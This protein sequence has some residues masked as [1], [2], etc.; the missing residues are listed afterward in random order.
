MIKLAPSI[1]AADF[2]R[3]GEVI[4]ET[5]ESEADLIH[6]DVMDGQ[7]VPNITLGADIVKAIRPYT[8]K[9]FD[10]HLMVD[11]PDR[12]I[13]QF[14]DAGADI[15]TVHV[16]TCAHLHRTIQMIKSRGIKAG[17]VL[18]PAT[19][20]DSIDPILAELD[21]VLLMSVNPGYGGQVFIPSTLD[22]IRQLRRKIANLSLDIDI[23]IDG[24]V[25]KDNVKAIL[26]A[27]ANVIVAG[28]AIYRD[29]DIKTSI[30]TF[31]QGMR[32]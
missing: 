24:G 5:G 3:L 9:P 8:D 4:K 28:S 25:N 2:S 15:I 19:P 13:D 14:A 23:E 31:K 6:I 10:V 1:L 26:D 21:M 12:F 22:K 30:Q 7:F 20:V 16:E 17:V 29:A 32:K 27:G 11:H 18:N